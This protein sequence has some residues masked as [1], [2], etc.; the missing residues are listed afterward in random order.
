VL[1]CNRFGQQALG[2]SAG[3]KAQNGRV[4]DR[5]QH[6][7]PAILAF[8]FE[9]PGAFQPVHDRHQQVNENE[10]GPEQGQFIQRLPAITESYGQGQVGP[11]P[12]Y[13]LK[14]QPDRDIIID[15]GHR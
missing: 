10:V 9:A 5:R 6:H 1:S 4:R 13:A 2:A 14:V 8:L 12:G 15:N 7:N 3:G 11:M